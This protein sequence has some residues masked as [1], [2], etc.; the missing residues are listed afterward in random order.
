MISLFDLWPLLFEHFPSARGKGAAPI[1]LF[2]L[3]VHRHFTPLVPLLV[4]LHFLPVTLIDR[5]RLRLRHRS[6]PLPIEF[7]SSLVLAIQILIGPLFVG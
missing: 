6:S 2:L 7:F 3:P 4:P 1:L 5:F